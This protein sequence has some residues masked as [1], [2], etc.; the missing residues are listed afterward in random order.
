MLPAGHCM[1]VLHAGQVEGTTRGMTRGMTHLHGAAILAEHALQ[2]ILQ[3]LLPWLAGGAAC[4]TKP[5]IFN[6]CAHIIKLWL[7]AMAPWRVV[8]R[9]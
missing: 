4:S 7:N 6:P 2:P 9:I 3:Y 5:G 8:T 1:T